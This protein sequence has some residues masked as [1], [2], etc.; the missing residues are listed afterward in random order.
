MTYG[1]RRQGW[2]TKPDET[3]IT[4]ADE[5]FDLKVIDNAKEYK[6]KAPGLTPSMPRNQK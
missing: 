1:K 5:D 2:G 3:D 4:P 6:P